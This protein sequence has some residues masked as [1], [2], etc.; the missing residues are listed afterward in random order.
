[1]PC[2]VYLAFDFGEKRIGIAI[3]NDATESARGLTTLSGVNGQERFDAI[4]PIVR[5]WEPHA[6][7]V[8]HP[9]HPDGSAHAMT[10]RAEKF[11]RQLE[12]RFHR[13]ALLI[14]ERYS[15]VDAEHA[16]RSRGERISKANLDAEA[17]AEILQRFFDSGLHLKQ[18]EEILHS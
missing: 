9:T 16:L 2:N 10:V 1:M 13:K 3:G 5:E 4:A 8:G 12:G 17:A 6:F 15:S 14:D 18:R 11:A 7:I